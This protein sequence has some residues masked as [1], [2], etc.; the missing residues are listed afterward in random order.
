VRLA[1]LGASV[2]SIA[3]VPVGV[4]LATGGAGSSA[5][6]R[7]A[8]ATVPAL[9]YE[10]A[11]ANSTPQ[12]WVASVTG[13]NAH[14]LG[15]G[16]QPLLAPDGAFVAASLF[17]VQAGE[18]SGPAVVLYPTAGG[19]P[20]YRLSLR[21]ATYQLLAWSAD[22]RY[23]A[24]ETQGGAELAESTLALLDTTTG[25]VTTLAHGQ[26]YGASFAPNGSDEVV[27]GLAR[28]LSLSARVNIYVAHVDGSD[29]HALT[30]DGRSLNPLWG[31]T[32]IAFDRE[33]L[34]HDDAPVFQ[35]WEMHADGKHAVRLTS[36]KIP[37]LVEG[38]VPFAF[39]ASGARLLTEYEGQDTSAAWT[40]TVASRHV[41]QLLVKGQ[42][43]TAAGISRG[44]T[45]VLVGQGSFERPASD[46]RV[47]M[48]PYGGGEPT[49]VVAHG[50][51]PS[52]ND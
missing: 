51:L 17:G 3:T 13:A 15:P 48:L 18:A 50:A 7:A 6:G 42:A 24:L 37:T 34:R 32:A 19:V 52:W 41:H 33:R 23:L 43:V 11:T 25:A 27:F 26:I 36:M 5:P 31:P 8:L 28:S 40:L 21:Q 45:K 2:A 49:V 47:E 39:S 1:I 20:T 38:L 9:T 4:A 12:V 35:V 44:G 30:T 16:Q 22:S 46:G 10:T 29:R 14:R